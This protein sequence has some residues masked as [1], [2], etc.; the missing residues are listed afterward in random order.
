MT[1]RQ[2][3]NLISKLDQIAKILS[4]Q[5]LPGETLTERVRVLKS[6]GLTNGQISDILNVAEPTIRA[7]SSRIN[8]I[9]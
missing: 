3:E 2:Y 5:I 9:K 6:L 7:L 1:D 8:K 4:F